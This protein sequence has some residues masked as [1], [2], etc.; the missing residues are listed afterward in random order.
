VKRPAKERDASKQQAL[1]AYKK[2]LKLDPNNL[3]SSFNLGVYHYNKG[4]E[5]LKKVNDMDIP[6]YQAKGKKLE[7]EAQNEFKA[8]LPYF[9]ACYQI[10][11]TD[12]GVKKSLKNTYERLGRNADSEKIGK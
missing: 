6:T 3:E 1:T 2:A 12:E 4:A 5:V 8:A 7:T 10:N 9:E 11:K